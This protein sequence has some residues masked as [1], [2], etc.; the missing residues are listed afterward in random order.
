[1]T[2]SGNQLLSALGSGIQ[3]GVGL[4]ASGVDQQKHIESMDFSDV[5]LRVQQ[6][7]S[8]QLGI[9]L[10]T[11]L[12]PSSVSVKV[13]EAASRAA[14]IAAIKGIDQA[15]VDLGESIVRLDVKN[16]VIK[17]QFEPAGEVVIDQIDGFVSIQP[18]QE[19]AEDTET[20]GPQISSVSAR[21]VRN[22]SLVDV[23]SALTP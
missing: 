6:G 15:V 1:V 21:V 18:D 17:A 9:Q 2:I 3:P 23:L 10:S 8:S 12:L 22:P 5:L 11:D 7:Q 13:R 19:S 20:I 16:R 14:D 4:G